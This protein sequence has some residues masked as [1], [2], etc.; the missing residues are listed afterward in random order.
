MIKR[1]IVALI[2]SPITLFLMFS[3]NPYFFIGL[4]MLALTIALN[5]MYSMLAKKKMRAYAITGNIFALAVFALVIIKPAP[6]YYFACLGLFAV[7][8]L[9]QVVVSKDEKN[10]IRVF[11]T[12]TPVMYITALGTFGIYLRMLPQGSWF[13]F[14]LLLLT[15]IYDSGAYFVGTAI[16]KNKLIPELSPGKT[17]EGCI[18]G[19]VVNVITA[20]IIYFTLFAAF[21][22]QNLLGPDTLLHFIILAVLLAF[23][24]QI[25][26]LAESAFKRYTGVKNSSNLLPGHGGA[27]DR[28]D[29]LM[30]NAPVLYLYL[31]LILRIS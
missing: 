20:V 29:S 27:L 24:G 18:G 9:A 8:A 6:A 21:K 2:I 14:I 13:I 26:D 15:L 3:K 16:G 19:L 10:L 23:I 1:I 7:T 5:E 25:G 28:I 4:C 17:I 12:I 11:Y 22:V 30:F 31:T